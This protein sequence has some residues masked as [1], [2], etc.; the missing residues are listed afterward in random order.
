M[1]YPE[2]GAYMK[3]TDVILFGCGLVSLGIP[4]LFKEMEQVASGVFFVVGLSLIV[5]ASI[6]A[7]R[8]WRKPTTAAVERIQMIEVFREA[9]KG[10]VYLF[11]DRRLSPIL[12]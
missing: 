8:D 2:K 10:G 12:E 3:R 7:A 6:D 11:E 5:I 4:A 1:S 9:H